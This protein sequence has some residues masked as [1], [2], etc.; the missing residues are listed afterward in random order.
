MLR[1]IASDV[2]LH[3]RMSYAPRLSDLPNLGPKSQ[4]ILMR[5]GITSLAQ[6]RKLGAVRAFVHA[7]RAGV[8]VSLNLLWSLDGAL[9]GVPWQTVAREHRAS[10]LLALED[11]EREVQHVNQH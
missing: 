9:T 6:L 1:S 5:A 2:R 4:Q 7:R 11:Y 3:N 8:G 10:L